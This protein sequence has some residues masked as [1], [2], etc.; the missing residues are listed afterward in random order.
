MIE[1]YQIKKPIGKKT[2]EERFRVSLSQDERIK[3]FAETSGHN[4]LSS[5]LRECALRGG[6][7]SNELH[8]KINFIVDWI[9]KQ[10]KK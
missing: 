4:T 10:D 7:A 6:V 9:K 5:Y 1:D 2:R 3:F 8:S